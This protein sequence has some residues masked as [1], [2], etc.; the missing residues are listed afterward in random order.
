MQ[1]QQRHT[2]SPRLEKRTDEMMTFIYV[3]YRLRCSRGYVFFVSNDSEN[4]CQQGTNEEL[5][6]SN[7]P[8]FAIVSLLDLGLYSLPSI[9]PVL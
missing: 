5:Y 7:A 9:C 1:Q 8:A 4:A 6:I 3:F 2:R